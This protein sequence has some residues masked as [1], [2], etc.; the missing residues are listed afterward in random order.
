MKLTMWCCVRFHANYHVILPGLGEIILIILLNCS[1]CLFVIEIQRQKRFS[2]SFNLH[3][4]SARLLMKLLTLAQIKQFSEWYLS[5]CNS[6]WYLSFCKS[7]WYMSFYKSEWYLSFC[8]SE[9]YL[10]FYK[11]EWFIERQVSFT[12]IERQV[13]FTI[14]ERQVSFTII[15]RQVSFTIL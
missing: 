5:F 4:F 15:E 2:T 9:W 7:E 8:K 11:S 14:I 1:S 13:S 3:S 6:E 12:I 10:S